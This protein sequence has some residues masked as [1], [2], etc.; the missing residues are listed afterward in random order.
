MSFFKHLLRGWKGNGYY[1]HHGKRRHGHHEDYG[2]DGYG[3]P[4]VRGQVCAQCGAGNAAEA[5]F[6]AQCG[7]SLQS[8]PCAACGTEVPAA[9]KFC[10]NCGQAAK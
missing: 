9:A 2:D 6:C 10:P 3:S 1:G 8:A 5:R 4:R 7:A